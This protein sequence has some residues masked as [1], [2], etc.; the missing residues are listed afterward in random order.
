MKNICKEN[1]ERFG[2]KLEREI[3]KQ[4]KEVVMDVILDSIRLMVAVAPICTAR[5]LR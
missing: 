5:G 3:T 1:E 2:K 4:E